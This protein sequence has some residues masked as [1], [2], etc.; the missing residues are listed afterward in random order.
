MDSIARKKQIIKLLM[1]EV[2]DYSKALDQSKK[3]EGVED[4]NLIKFKDEAFKEAVEDI[5]A[6]DTEEE[7][8]SHLH[9]TIRL[10]QT[11]ESAFFVMNKVKDVKGDLFK[12]MVDDVTDNTPENLADFLGEIAGDIAEDIETSQTDEHIDGEEDEHRKDGSAKAE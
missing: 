1:E 3:K 8:T 7:I 2:E 12:G 5:E 6:I 10:F 11:I 4:I 9:Q